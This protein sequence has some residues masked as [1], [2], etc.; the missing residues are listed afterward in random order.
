MTSA[1]FPIFEHSASERNALPVPRDR[2]VASRAFCA[3]CGPVSF[4]ALL[5][6]LVVDVIRFFPQF[7]ATPYTTIPQMK[8]ALKESGIRYRHFDGW[9]S[10]GLCLIQFQG[11]WT[12]R[13]QY[14]EAAKHRHWV[15]VVN[16]S[17]YDVNLHKW[18]AMPDWD[19]FITQHLVEAHPERVGWSLSKSFDVFPELQFLPQFPMPS[20]FYA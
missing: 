2:D 13:N 9:P 19:S 15:A 11:P 6:A 16:G 20:A 14:R 5:G 12:L 18:L 1:C 10:C 3:N 8:H 7:P 17:V 4:A